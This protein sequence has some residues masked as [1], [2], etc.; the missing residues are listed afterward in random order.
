MKQVIDSSNF[1]GIEKQL[2]YKYTEFSKTNQKY[3][4]RISELQ[5]LFIEA[6]KSTKSAVSYYDLMLML[7]SSDTISD[8]INDITNMENDILGICNEA[9]AKV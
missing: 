6:D 1:S 2:R 4:K 9:N 3:S 8:R 5:K 7:K